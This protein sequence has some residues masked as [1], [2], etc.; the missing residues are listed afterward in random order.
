M[1]TRLLTHQFAIT[2]CARLLKVKAL[3]RDM[4]QARTDQNDT[5]K[6]FWTLDRSRKQHSSG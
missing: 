3:A 4:L 1:L 2:G 6:A 5:R